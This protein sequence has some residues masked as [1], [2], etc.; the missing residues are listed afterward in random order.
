MFQVSTTLER[1]E[2]WNN[3]LAF[4]P[5]MQYP[6]LRQNTE[7]GAGYTAGGVVNLGVNWTNTATADSDPYHPIPGTL[8]GV[9]NL[10]RGSTLPFDTT[11]LQPLAG[12]ALVDAA[13]TPAS[14]AAATAAHPLAYQLNAAG[15]RVARAVNGAASD[16]GAI[17]R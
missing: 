17:E 2:A 12:G 8:A 15:Q 9:T 3:V 6:S 7:I 4:A 11:T 5:S 16:L 10:R 1:A 13:S 14:L